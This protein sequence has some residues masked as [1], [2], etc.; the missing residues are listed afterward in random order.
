MVALLSAVSTTVLAVVINFATSDPAAVPAWLRP[1]QERPWP[2]IILLTAAV[3]LLALLTAR[4]NGTGGHGPSNRLGRPRRVSPADRP[5]LRVR[6]ADQVQ[7]EWIKKHLDEPVAGAPLNPRLVE[8]PDAVSG[9]RQAHVNPPRRPELPLPD[10]TTVTEV[11]RQHGWR[12]LILGEPGAGKTIALLGLTRDLLNGFDPK[13]GDPVPVV[14]DL[15]SWAKLRRPLAEWL[16]EELQQQYGLLPEYATYAVARCDIAPMLIGLDRVAAEHRDACVAAIN[17]FRTGPRDVP[18]VVSSRTSDYDAA[19]V[20]VQRGGAVVV[21]PLTHQQVDTYLENA[22]LAFT[23]LRA[24]VRRDPSLLALL[25]TPLMLGIA[26]K[27]YRG[28]HADEIHPTGYRALFDAYLDRALPAAT[29]D[30]ELPTTSAVDDGVPTYRREDARRWLTWLARQ[31]DRRRETV[32]QPDSLD[33]DWLPTNRQRLL[34]ANI[35]ESAV[36][37]PVA[38]AVC[39]GL[40]SGR[41][42]GT[43]PLSALD[44]VAA[45]FLGLLTAAL[46]AGP[47]KAQ[48]RINADLRW[49]WSS[50]LTALRGRAVAVWLLG[51]LTAAV[52]AVLTIGRVGAGAVL[53]LW[54]ITA[55]IVILDKGFQVHDGGRPVIPD[56][57]LRTA[58]RNSMRVWGPTWLI[59]GLIAGVLGVAVDGLGRRLERGLWLGLASTLTVWLVGAVAT[60][61]TTGLIL[62]LSRRQ[63]PDTVLPRRRTAAVTWTAAAAGGVAGWPAE[64]ILATF[65]QASGHFYIRLPVVTVAVLLFT[66]VARAAHQRYDPLVG[67][68]SGAFLLSLSAFVATRLI[69]SAISVDGLP[70]FFAALVAAAGCWLGLTAGGAMWL[71]QMALRAVLAHNKSIPRNLIAFLDDADHRGVLRR[72]G[73]GYMFIHGLVRAHVAEHDSSR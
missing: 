15:S 19:S 9:A 47:D 17:E 59:G 21:Q 48:P 10:G 40:L 49:R 35:A 37:L 69:T 26:T 45:V 64:A 36:A 43:P 12:L 44:I 39:L 65:S 60:A 14:F 11:A 63:P 57:G 18:L 28:Q 73:G 58:Q 31:L 51:G 42:P 7:Q 27:V 71:R 67:T 13:S 56:G 66:H 70:L 20:T 38:M 52:L 62:V 25:T 55:A 5:P 3:G 16:V 32:F 22:G 54:M 33:L 6:L 53:M 4:Q 72:T 41:L 8:R 30:D 24:A 61:T 29:T 23:G 34:V 1:L 2:A 68:A 46:V 50:V